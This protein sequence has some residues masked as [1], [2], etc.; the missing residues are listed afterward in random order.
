MTYTETDMKETSFPVTA[1]FSYC[2]TDICVKYGADGLFV[3]L[4]CDFPYKNL[5]RATADIVIGFLD[6]KLFRWYPVP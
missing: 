2:M 4:M 6:F 3:R 1:S 5:C